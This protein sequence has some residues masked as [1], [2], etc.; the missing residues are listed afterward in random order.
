MTE[1]IGI[2]TNGVSHIALVCSDMGQTVRF[3]RDLLG[4]PLVKTL[5]LPAG[6]GQHFFFDIGGG[7][8]LAFFW[9][10]NT[11]AP[12]PGVASAP[13]LPD[14]GELASAVGSMNHLAFNVDSD[15]IEEFRD[16]LVGAGVECT[17]VWNHDNSQYGLSPTVTRD[18]F[19]RSVYFQ[20]PDGVLLELAAWTKPSFGSEDANHTPAG[21]TNIT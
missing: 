2:E 12:A 14:R 6:M 10:P 11:P 16:R 15:R 17:D 9:F 3:Y 8:H 7:D 5:E 19:V 4:F 20:D 13:M 18:V 21:A 1:P